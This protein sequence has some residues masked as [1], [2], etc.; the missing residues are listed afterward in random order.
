[1]CTVTSALSDSVR[2]YGLQPARLRCGILQARILGGVAVNSSRDLPN[3]GIEPLSLA[4][5]ASAGRFFIASVTWE[6]LTVSIKDSNRNA[7]NVLPQPLESTYTH[8]PPALLWLQEQRGS[9]PF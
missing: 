7:I 8:V 1:M 4:S 3:P 9:P 2:L 5:C 6:A